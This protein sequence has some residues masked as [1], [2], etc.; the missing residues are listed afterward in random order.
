VVPALITGA[1]GT[2]CHGSG[3]VALGDYAKAQA[4]SVR[5]SHVLPKDIR[6]QLVL[7]ILRTKEQSPLLIAV[8]IIGMCGLARERWE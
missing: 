3:R 7:L 6:D 5:I 1:T 4:L 2:R 8:S